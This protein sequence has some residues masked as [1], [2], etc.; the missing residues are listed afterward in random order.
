MVLSY[1]ELLIIFSI[2]FK[3][4]GPDLETWGPGGHKLVRALFPSDFDRI[5]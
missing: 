5:L 1:D 2:F 3:S 4:A